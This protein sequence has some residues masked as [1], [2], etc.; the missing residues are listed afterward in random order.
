MTRAQPFTRA[1]HRIKRKEFHIPR[2]LHQHHPPRKIEPA[3]IP[4]PLLRIKKGTQRH[5]QL[6]HYVNTKDT[7]PRLLQS[8]VI[9]LFRCSILDVRC[10]MFPQPFPRPIRRKEN[11]R[12][13]HHDPREHADVKQ[14]RRHHVKHHDGEI[15]PWPAA[16][17]QQPK[18]DRQIIHST[19]PARRVSH[20]GLRQ[21]RTDQG[22][23]A[24]RRQP[25]AHGLCL[26]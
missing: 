14:H 24:S 23:V 5:H 18:R 21:K 20:P 16:R 13:H 22:Q 7:Q 4:C 26:Q 10:S 9:P 19:R 25:D 8:P 3:P 17:P 2:L 1:R 11:H 15:R 12:R 6:Q